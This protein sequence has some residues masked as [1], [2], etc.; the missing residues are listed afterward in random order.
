M[1]RRQNCSARKT[2][3]FF[4]FQPWNS[5][6]KWV[7]WTEITWKTYL[8]FSFQLWITIRRISTLYFTSLSLCNR[9]RWNWTRTAWWRTKVRRSALS[10]N[11]SSTQQALHCI[12]YKQRILN[13]LK[14]NLFSSISLEKN[15]SKYSNYNL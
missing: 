6:Y 4:S 14:N 10:P 5:E 7:S 9:R 1:R 3:L 13:Q 12:F 8:F 15:S 2:C 11:I